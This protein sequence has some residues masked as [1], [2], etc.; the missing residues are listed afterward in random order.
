MLGESYTINQQT[1]RTVHEKEKNITEDPNCI[2][3]KAKKRI[4]FFDPKFLY[5]ILKLNSR[6]EDLR[7]NSEESKNPLIIL[8]SQIVSQYSYLLIAMNHSEQIYRNN[9][10][11]NGSN[12]KDYAEFYSKQLKENKDFKVGS[13]IKSN[14]LYLILEC[15]NDTLKKLNDILDTNFENPEK[16]KFSSKIISSNS[17]EE[18]NVNMSELHIQLNATKNLSNLRQDNN[19][20]KSISSDDSTR[21]LITP[22]ILESSVDNFL[23]KE[24]I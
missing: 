12:D 23:T 16:N 17:S 22:F 2:N 21:Y 13:I 5:Q 4:N 11:K 9:L 8:I 14:E 19:D 7:L 18:T 15:D 3:F 20:E 10:K 6:G 1:I 24:K